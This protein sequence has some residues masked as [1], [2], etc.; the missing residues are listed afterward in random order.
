M[1]RRRAISDGLLGGNKRWLILGSIAWAIRA[2]QWAATREERVV[3]SAELK[4][5]ETL[6]L[7]RQASKKTSRR[8]GRS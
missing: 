5:G 4:P 8:S 3:Y 7:A 6:V 1:A 2:Y